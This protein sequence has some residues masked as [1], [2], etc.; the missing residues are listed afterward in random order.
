[1]ADRLGLA[2]GARLHGVAE[3]VTLPLDSPALP[4]GGPREVALAV[5]RRDLDVGQKGQVL[6]NH[7]RAPVLPRQQRI[8]PESGPSHEK[9][10]VIVMI[11]SSIVIIIVI[12]KI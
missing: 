9:R 5:E 1:M 6:N 3:V 11:I 4:A 7:A 10:V 12:L 8:G 2:A